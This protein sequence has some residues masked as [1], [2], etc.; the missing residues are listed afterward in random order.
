M[1]KVLLLKMLLLKKKQKQ[2]NAWQLFIINKNVNF[3][4]RMT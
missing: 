1:L 2:N 4:A 3:L